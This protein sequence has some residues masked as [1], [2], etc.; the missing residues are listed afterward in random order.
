MIDTK[1]GKSPAQFRYLIGDCTGVVEVIRIGP[2]SYS[3]MQQAHG[4]HNEAVMLSRAPWNDERKQL[5][6]N[7]ATEI[8]PTPALAMVGRFEDVK[9]PMHDDYNE[10]PRLAKLT[11]ISMH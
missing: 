3:L 8:R 9:C 1:N 2:G 7:S 11:R 6:H 10:A 4:L 5:Q